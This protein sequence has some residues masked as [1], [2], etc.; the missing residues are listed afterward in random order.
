MS[1]GKVRMKIPEIQRFPQLG[2]QISVKGEIF[3]CTAVGQ[4][5][6]G[7]TRIEFTPLE[8]KVKSDQAFMDKLNLHD[9][10]GQ[11]EPNYKYDDSYTED[12][13]ND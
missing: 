9:L 6:R 2:E 4:D 10:G 13:E 8:L 7:V 11:V 3:Q 1:T 12:E 5:V